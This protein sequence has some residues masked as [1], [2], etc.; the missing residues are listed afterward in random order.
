MGAAAGFTAV[1]RFA[2][3]GKHFLTTRDLLAA[4]AAALKV[5]AR[6]CAPSSYEVVGWLINHRKVKGFWGWLMVSQ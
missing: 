1:L 6:R 2:L 3:R 4:R 5:L